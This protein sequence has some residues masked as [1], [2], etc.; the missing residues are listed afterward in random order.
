M[1]QSY[2]SV[3]LPTKDDENAFFARI[4]QSRE[5]KL[6]R[7]L[8]IYRFKYL[9]NRSCCSFCTSVLRR[10]PSGSGV[11]IILSMLG[12]EQIAFN[13]SVQ[14]II[15]PFLKATHFSSKGEEFFVRIIGLKLV[16]N[17]LFPIAG[18]I[19]DVWIGRY[20]MIYLSA[21]IMWFGYCLAAFAISFQMFG[22][23]WN[24][25]I[26]FPCYLI[27]NIG[28]AG[29][30]ASAIPFGADQIFYKT[31]HELSSYFYMYYWM[32]N[33]GFTMLFLIAEECR[34]GFDGIVNSLTYSAI[35]V[36]ATTAILC[37]IGVFS[38]KFTINDKKRNPLKT[39]CKVLYA[40][41]ITKR[42]IYRSAF[43]YT[44]VSRPSRIDLTKSI[45]GGL[46]EEETV[47]DVKT[48]LRLVKI[49]LPLFIVLTAYVGVSYNGS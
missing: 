5:A 19:A 16:A 46:F 24:N 15:S 49:F 21:W 35:G 20:R 23:N 40:C 34:N 17:L 25:Y 2:S 28:S 4:Q 36:I 18:W 29:F 9:F 41:A 8:H 14:G 3:E 32:R 6:K 11:Y 47:E 10:F 38:N 37:L 45:H 44:G 31:S 43:S 39:V 27:I 48:F 13:G 22:Q 30:Q 42:P 7:D 26:L 12:L 1:A 33:F